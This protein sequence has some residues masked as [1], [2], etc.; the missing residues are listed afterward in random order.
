M[1]AARGIYYSGDATWVQNEEGG[2]WHLHTS[3]IQ[4]R[5]TGTQ[6]NMRADPINAPSPVAK[7]APPEPTRAE[8]LAKIEAK[9]DESFAVAR[10]GMWNAAVDII[11][12]PLMPDSW[13]DKVKYDAPART[14]DA[15]R[16]YE[17]QEDYEGGQIVT[18]TVAIA[19][20]M[21]PIAETAEAAQLAAGKLPKPSGGLG[22][23]AQD[24][25]SFSDAWAAGAETKTAGEL[26][27]IR[28]SPAPIRG[29]P[30]VTGPGH[31]ERM[32]EAA[33]ELSHVPDAA[34]VS[35]HRS[36]KSATN[37]AVDSAR[38]PDVIMVSNSGGV[39]AVEVPS[40]GDLRSAKTFGHLI[41]R[42][43]K[44]QLRIPDTNEGLLILFK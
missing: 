23:I 34:E 18:H 15:L 4:T 19:V 33:N 22:I 1:F 44:V 28:S 32:Q 41:A 2:Y 40:A 27:P 3:Q 43:L 30:Q 37:G 36:Y 6:L 10:K 13:K 38:K 17:L 8:K 29:N 20:S 35:M 26:S 25:T 11:A 21:L 12:P 5:D 42:N 16:D 7:P 24:F 9:R 14:G 31:A 39:T